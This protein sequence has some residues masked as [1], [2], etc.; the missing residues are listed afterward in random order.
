MALYKIRLDSKIE[1]R[2]LDFESSFFEFVQIG[3]LDSDFGFEDTKNFGI[4]YMGL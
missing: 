4:V 1:S 2:I 3:M